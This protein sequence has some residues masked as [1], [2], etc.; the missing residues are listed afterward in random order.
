[1][2]LPV[3]ERS[4]L[5]RLMLW[6]ALIGVSLGLIAYFFGDDV[7]TFIATLSNPPEEEP[8]TLSVNA[9]WDNDGDEE[10]DLLDGSEHGVGGARLTLSGPE[11]IEEL[12]NSVGG[13]IISDITPGTY[14]ISAV[15]EGQA[16]E[17]T[18]NTV[19]LVSGQQGEALLGLSSQGLEVAAIRGGLFED[20][21]FNGVHD[22]GEPG[23]PD[24]VVT[25]RQDLAILE[26]L[27]TGP[28]GTFVFED[29]AVGSYDV[30]LQPTLEQNKLFAFVGER[31]VG[32]KIRSGADIQEV[33]FLAER[34][35]IEAPESMAP[36]T[37]RLVQATPGVDGFE[38]LK[39]GSDA[40]E[41]DVEFVHA[42]PGGRVSFEITVRAVGNGTTT[43]PN[44]KIVDDYQDFMTISGITGGG[45]DDGDKITWDI[46]PLTVG[47]SAKVSYQATIATTALEGLFDNVA[48]VTATGATPM[49][50]DTTVVITKVGEPGVQ[51]NTTIRPTGNRNVITPSGQHVPEVGVPAW[52]VVA[53]ISLP[54][55]VIGTILLLGLRRATS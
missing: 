54:V 13:A 35:V 53:F 29:L 17:V 43:F 48:T 37:Y 25:L 14:A 3:P 44:T 47:G 12:T 50:D 8:A 1:M 30:R 32:V 21:N 7:V 5:R 55:V 11:T 15:L 39:L 19:T 45:I 2:A 27:E 28:D 46:G 6:F 49:D 10:L 41:T 4:R 42:K 40:D 38:I 22:S 20:V 24:V 23:I 18:P 51:P 33:F 34:I 16:L 31:Q 9:F 52:A 36:G 26:Q